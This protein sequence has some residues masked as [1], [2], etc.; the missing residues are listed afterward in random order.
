MPNLKVQYESSISNLSLFFLKQQDPISYKAIMAALARLGA[1]IRKLMQSIYQSQVG[2]SH[3]LIQ[4]KD[5]NRI[6]MS[7]PNKATSSQVW[8]TEVMDLMW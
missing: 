2:Y 3:H 7:Y 1:Q 4:N 6:K 5:L 8:R